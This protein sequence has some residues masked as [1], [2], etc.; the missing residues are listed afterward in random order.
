MI[1]LI[2]NDLYFVVL[3]LLIIYRSLKC[4]SELPIVLRGFKKWEKFPFNDYK[5]TLYEM[6]VWMCTFSILWFFKNEED[7]IYN[8]K[9]FQFKDFILMLFVDE[10]NEYS[11]FGLHT[12][13]IGFTIGIVLP[14]EMSSISHK[15]E[16]KEEEEKK[17]RE[18]WR[19]Y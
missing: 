17:R 15:K 3:P 16:I 10:W 4:I 12:F 2:I 13:L 14:F 6:F 7:L 5:R 9:P 18:K 8:M 1:T 11:H 19:H